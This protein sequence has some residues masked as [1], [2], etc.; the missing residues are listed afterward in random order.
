MQ[1]WRQTTT[2]TTAWNYTQA[3]RRFLR[4]LRTHGG[5]DL[6]DELPR[7]R[8][9][10]ARET[11]AQPDELQRLINHA[12]PWFRLHLL[13]CSQLGLRISESLS[14]TRASWNQEAHTLTFTGK[15][16]RARTMPTLP[17]IDQLLAL[18]PTEHPAHQI[19]AALK[20]VET[21]TTHQLRAAWKKLKL[22]AR[23]N[24]NLNPHDLRRTAATQL[25]RHTK[26]IRAVQ[27]LLGHHSLQ[28]TTTYL[29]P[30]DPGEL[31]A[32]LLDL[33]TPTETKQ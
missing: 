11:I 29:A 24:P 32:L 23:V 16:R 30:L 9:P 19:L 18:A 20:G 5:P 28:A 4:H 27:Q 31:E 26:D 22:R 17:E 12:Q 13:L 15:G 6:V 3:L 7:L 14:L 10:T 25:Y 33:K 21:L 8:K 1:R 2:P